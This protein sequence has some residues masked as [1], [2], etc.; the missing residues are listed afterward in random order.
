MEHGAGPLRL[1]PE[2]PGRMVKLIVATASDAAKFHV[3]ILSEAKDLLFL[4][5]LSSPTPIG[6]PESLSSPTQEKD[7]DTGFTEMSFPTLV[8]GNPVSLSSRTKK[9]K[10]P[11]FL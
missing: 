3:V 8:I 4:S 11:G 7:K 9:N 1:A 6:D 2:P 10:N 5:C